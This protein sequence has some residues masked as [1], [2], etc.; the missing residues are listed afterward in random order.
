MKS[1]FS[2][3]IELV[4]LEVKNKTPRRGRK[5]ETSVHKIREFSQA[6]R[7]NKYKRH[8]QRKAHTLHP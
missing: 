3:R 6:E 7:K 5:Q 4:R 2:G 1:V 8:K